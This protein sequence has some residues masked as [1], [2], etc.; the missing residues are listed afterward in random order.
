MGMLNVKLEH[1]SESVP[2]QQML[3]VE[4]MLHGDYL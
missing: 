4:N 3:F 2:L 1:V